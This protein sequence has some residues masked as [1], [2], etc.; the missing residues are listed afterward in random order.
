MFTRKH[1]LVRVVAYIVVFVLAYVLIGA[2]VLA[3]FGGIF[4]RVCGVGLPP[5]SEW[6]RLLV[7]HVDP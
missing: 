4:R 6:L 5:P 2:I 3:I 1:I 7:V